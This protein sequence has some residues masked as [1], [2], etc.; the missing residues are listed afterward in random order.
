MVSVIACFTD[1]SRTVHVSYYRG[2]RAIFTNK[3][4]IAAI[5]VFQDPSINITELK[6]IHSEI[7]LTVPDPILLQNLHDG[8]E[9]VRLHVRV[10]LSVKLV[11]VYRAE[12]T[13]FFLSQQ[14]AK[15]RK[16]EDGGPEDMGE[17]KHFI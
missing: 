17:Y 2:H 12:V 6:E 8:L 7:N 9:A 15:K 14:N 13:S 10:K 3:N 1:M 5:L 11:T 16:L 4:S